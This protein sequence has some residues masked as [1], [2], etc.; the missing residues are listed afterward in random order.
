MN[1]A[2]YYFPVWNQK[3]VFS[4]LTRLTTKWHV[5]PNMLFG[6][7]QNWTRRSFLTSVGNPGY[8]GT[9]LPGLPVIFQTQ[10][11]GKHDFSGF[12]FRPG[13]F[14]CQ[15][16]RWCVARH[17]VNGLQSTIRRIATRRQQLW[18]IAAAEA[19]DALICGLDRCPLLRTPGSHGLEQFNS[20]ILYF[21]VT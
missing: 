12:G 5:F 3:A 17:R 15:E 8:P 18:S 6:K 2:T 11:T 20:I 14:S 13:K 9:R 7:F 19:A 21:R 10:M 16:T 1:C 4:W